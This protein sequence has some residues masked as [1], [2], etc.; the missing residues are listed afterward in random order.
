M[1]IFVETPTGTTI[2]QKVKASDTIKDVK[3]KIQGKVGIPP[4]EQRL[5]FAKKLLEDGHTLNDY[6]IQRESTLK[7]RGNYVT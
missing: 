5:V 4:D 3:T 1:W 7:L 2:A 6:R